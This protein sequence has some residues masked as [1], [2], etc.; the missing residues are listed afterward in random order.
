MVANF[1]MTKV[2]ERKNKGQIRK[3]KNISLVDES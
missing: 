1:K 2:F 3:F